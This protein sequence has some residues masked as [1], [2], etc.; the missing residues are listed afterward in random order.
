[1][2]PASLVI[3]A[4][5]GLSGCVG[6]PP[7]GLPDA[8]SSTID[9]QIL[10]FNDFHGNLEPPA[11]SNGRVNGVEVGGVEYFATHLA[12]LEATNPHT[13]IV[14]AGDNIG[15]SPLLSALFHDEPTIEALGTFGLDFSTVG[16]HEFDEGWRELLRMQRGGCHP[17]DGC[18][19]STPFAGAAFKY[20]SANVRVNDT[21]DTLFPAT[22]MMSFDG[23]PVGFIG[24][25]LQ[26]TPTLVIPTAVDGVTFLPEA[27][28]ANEAARALRAQGAAAV[29]ALIHQGG[30]ISATDDERCT[31]MTGEFVPIVRQMSADIDVVVSGHTNRSYICRMDGKLVT[32][33]AS[34]SRFI[35]DIDL[36]ID[37]RTR[38]VVES[39]ARNL[40]VTRDVP[41]EA[42]QTA[43]LDRY[44]PTAEKVGGRPVGSISGTIVRAYN[45]AGESP[46]GGVMADA[47]LAFAQTADNGGAEIGI[48]NYGGIR[49]D[50]VHPDGAAATAPHQLTYKDVF[51][52]MPFGNTI[53]VK[54]I[55]GEGLLRIL[56][57]QFDNPGS[58]ERTILQVSHSVRYSYDPRRPAGA[59]VNRES[60]RIDGR[61]LDP[62]ASYRVAMSDFLWN[63]GDGFS[64]AAAGTEPHALGLDID[65]FLAYLAAHSPIGPPQPG[66]I[67]LER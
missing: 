4:L 44:R 56:E 36:K 6:T 19:G 35:T 22:A 24:L 49:A 57:Q 63:G 45:A 10:A 61:R 65:V 53:L 59:R 50:F 25:A 15:A 60:I 9:V 51:T 43:I 31:T 42:A 66:R 30:Y 40:L 20:L 7:P 32:S 34:Y 2:R 58:G 8:A 17:V 47:F 39:T 1:M 55:T 46:M 5:A 21:A 28:A 12:Q 18:R 23:V 33:T 37:R 13:A 14:S 11:G 64:T 54:T 67:V 3:L 27:E 29:V 62:S 26:G 16:N 38:R 48:M 41:R 52:L